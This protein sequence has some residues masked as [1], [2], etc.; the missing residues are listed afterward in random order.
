VPELLEGQPEPRR[1]VAPEVRVDGVG[2][3]H[4][5][6]EN[7]PRVRMTQ[8]EG[9]RLLVPV[10]GLEEQRVLAL[11]ERRHV[12]SHVPAGARILDLDHLRAEVGELQRR[13][14]AG[15]ELLDGDDPDVLERQGHAPATARS[16]ASAASIIAVSICGFG[17]FGNGYARFECVS[18]SPRTSSASL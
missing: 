6:L 10:E 7:G 15:A 5:I 1:T 3:A 17:T 8:V 18:P 12:A 13:P 4:E 11:L 14:R 9:E 2:D 16:L